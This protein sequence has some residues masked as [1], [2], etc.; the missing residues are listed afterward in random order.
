M[1]YL[2]SDLTEDRI[3]AQ[4]ILHAEANMIEGQLLRIL[5]PYQGAKVWKISG[6]GGAISKLKGQLE[7]YCSDH[8]YNRPGQPYWLNV[9][10]AYNSLIAN[11]RHHNASLSLDIHLGRFNE[12][13]GDL[14]KLHE[15]QK[16]RTDFTL[17][18]VKQ[19]LAEAKELEE[20]ARQL[21]SSIS[22]FARS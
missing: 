4:N 3:K 14:T 22:V 19:S 17:E 15:G 18:E 9:H 13:T 10:S 8:G 2:S 1:L 6:Y 21:R 7:Q 12:N 20:R 16:R 5:S 11:L